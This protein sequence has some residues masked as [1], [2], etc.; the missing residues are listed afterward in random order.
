LRHALFPGLALGAI[1]AA[2]FP[3]P[4]STASGVIGLIAGPSSA[5][6]SL[7]LRVRPLGSL[8]LAFAGANLRTWQRHAC[9]PCSASL[10]CC[11]GSATACGDA[12][13]QCYGSD[14]L[15]LRLPLT[16]KPAVPLWR[17]RRRFGRFSRILPRS[18]VLPGPDAHF[19]TPFG[20]FRWAGL[21]GGRQSR[22]NRADAQ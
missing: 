6:R 4:F 8:Q 11:A 7:K 13:A 5:L 20:A 18:R 14:L 3:T 21:M 19:V 10:L 12:L 16:H 22:P 2:S 15:P 1:K 17:R 9:D